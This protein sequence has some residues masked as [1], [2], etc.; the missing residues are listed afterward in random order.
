METHEGESKIASLDEKLANES[1]VG[2][3]ENFS[4]G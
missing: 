2:A 1:W 4:G 3:P